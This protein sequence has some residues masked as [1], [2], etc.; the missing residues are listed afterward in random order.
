MI[1]IRIFITVIL[2]LM[3]IY[4]AMLILQCLTSWFRMTNRD[5]TFGRCII[6]FYY[7]IAPVE[8]RKKKRTSDYDDEEDEEIA[9]REKEINDN[10][11]KEDRKEDK[12]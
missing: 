9:A 4:Y 3:A 2:F 11:N 10:L 6:P 1:W 12:F 8:E 7:W 5:I